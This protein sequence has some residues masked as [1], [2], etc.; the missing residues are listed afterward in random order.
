MVVLTLTLAAAGC[1][2]DGGT[3]PEPIPPA[4]LTPLN[5]TPANTMIRFEKAYAGEMVSA[6]AGLFT[7][8]FRFTF[9][10]SDPDLVSQYGLGWSTNN[11]TDAARH[12]FAGFTNAYGAYVPGASV[13]TLSLPGISFVDDPTKPDSGAWYRLATVPSVALEVSLPGGDGF[14]VTARQHFYLVRGDV[15]FLGTGQPGPADRWYIR[16]WDD[17]SGPLAPAALRPAS[18]SA[19]PAA[20]TATTWGSLKARY[21]GI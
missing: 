5:D 4:A 11:E 12:L 18:W 16:R 19:G 6:Y 20:S 21:S 17:K 2:G 13:I 9:S 15:A 3:S 7:G 10:P 8:D 14:T 1:S